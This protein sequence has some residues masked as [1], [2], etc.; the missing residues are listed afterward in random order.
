M[1]MIATLFS[2]NR[3]VLAASLL[4]LVG[5]VASARTH[6]A[7]PPGP[8]EALCR[9]N[10]G[11]IYQ[12]IQAYRAENK[13]LPAWLSDL[14]P[15]FLKDPNTLVCPVVK[16]TGAVNDFGIQDPNISTAYTYEFSDTVI[17]DVIQ[18]G[19]TRTMEDWKRRQMG[20]V[21][22]RVPMVRCHHHERV[23][24]LDFDGR[25]YESGVAWEAELAQ[26]IDPVDLSAGRIFA[27]ETAHAAAL[28]ARAAIPPRDPK[29]P[30]NLI[31]LSRF[32]NASLAESWHQNEP[33]DPPANDLEWL[34]RGVQKF[35]GVEFDTRG[36]IQLSSRQLKHPRFT[37]GI[38][39]VRID[40]KAERLHFLHGT[41]WSAPE[42][43]PVAH[44]IIRLANGDKHQFTIRYG[45]HVSDWIAQAGEPAD[46]ENS[47]VVWTGRSPATDSQ[48]LLHI[49]K[50]QWVNPTPGETI[51]TL[52]Y[53]GAHEDPA[54]FLIAI[55]AE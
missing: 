10:L 31:D 51:T 24:N 33:G 53:L 32:Y 3:F 16:K 1:L 12:A 36:V 37:S 52:D 19:A 6:A 4:A 25:I 41:G 48:T 8:D 49:Y 38:R 47:A 20:L 27:S 30:A 34:P 9:K 55:T 5:F 26:V 29:T 13:D 45:T 7:Q 42:G 50:T 35:G 46:S 40:R 15:R 54:P 14:V 21:G 11:A 2:R 23:L 17:P 39:N 44:V 43:T 18:V 22:S 28:R